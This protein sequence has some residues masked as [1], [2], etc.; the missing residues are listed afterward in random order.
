M[1]CMITAHTDQHGEV[2]MTCTSTLI[3][4]EDIHNLA[5]LTLTLLEQ[6]S[7]L[8]WQDS[9]M[10]GSWKMLSLFQSPRNKIL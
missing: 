9:T 8:T 10:A 6:T 7:K 2:A 3:P 1:L 5:M 4:R